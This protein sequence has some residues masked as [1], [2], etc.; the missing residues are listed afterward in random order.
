MYKLQ[1]YVC[2]V[3]TIKHIFQADK[4]VSNNTSRAK[5]HVTRF[6]EMAI[7]F[8]ELIK[9]Y[10]KCHICPE[11]AGFISTL[12]LTTTNIVMA[13][14]ATALKLSSAKTFCLQLFSIDCVTS[15][16]NL[17]VNCRCKL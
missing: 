14:A 2:K 9:S 8:S 7:N 1:M 17:V 6:L 5:S 13:S 11:S 3:I 15:S 16:I 10:L 12:K 4:H